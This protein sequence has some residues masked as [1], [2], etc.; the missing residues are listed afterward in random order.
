MKA[1]DNLVGTIINK[2]DVLGNYRSKKLDTT[3]EQSSMTARVQRVS[4]DS[5]IAHR[6][7]TWLARDVRLHL[8]HR[9]AESK[10][11]SIFGYDYIEDLHKTHDNVLA[12]PINILP[13]RAVKRIIGDYCRDFNGQ[14]KGQMA[15]T[16]TKIVDSYSAGN[17]DKIRLCNDGEYTYSVIFTGGKDML[18]M[19]H[20][21]EKGTYRLQPILI[22]VCDVDPVNITNTRFM[23]CNDVKLPNN[24]INNNFLWIM[25]QV[26]LGLVAAGD[27][28]E[29]VSKNTMMTKFEMNDSDQ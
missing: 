17:I 14:T 24:A 22:S 3:G 7:P 15:N 4:K 23:Y 25:E 21:N 8:A 18:I 29:F 28:V 19:R 16:L 2:R 27:V 5:Y 13:H 10:Y 1:I 12:F 6:I 26:A 9:L 20:N 11:I